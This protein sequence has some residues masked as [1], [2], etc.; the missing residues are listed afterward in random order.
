M[1]IAATM[2]SFAQLRGRIGVAGMLLRKLP[3]GSAVHSAQSEI[4]AA[5]VLSVLQSQGH[6]L[7]ADEKARLSSM[8]CGSAFEEKD[9]LDMLAQLSLRNGSRR[10][11]LAEALH[12][13]PAMQPCRFGK[14]TSRGWLQNRRLLDRSSSEDAGCLCLGHQLWLQN[15][16]SPEPIEDVWE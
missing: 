16:Q 8:I 11:A 15:G 1:K 6:Q 9:A 2:A 4:Q 5:A 7:T 12:C 14:G 13:E 3:M 10:A